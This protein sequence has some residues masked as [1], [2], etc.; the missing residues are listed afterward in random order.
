MAP[1]NES[2]K[3]SRNEET[4]AIVTGN[5]SESGRSTNVESISVDPE[6]YSD[7]DPYRTTR[8]AA[9][10]SETAELLEQVQI[11]PDGFER[12]TEQQL[13][14]IHEDAYERKKWSKTRQDGFIGILRLGR[15]TPARSKRLL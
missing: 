5:G 9:L 14:S 6:P 8:I 3:E 15:Q 4:K 11:Q 1:Q 2:N 10:R 12:V 13:R 7:A